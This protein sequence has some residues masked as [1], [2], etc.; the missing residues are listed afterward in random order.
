MAAE[1]EPLT[2]EGLDQP[3]GEV[4][5]AGE[6]VPVFGYAVEVGGGDF[7]LEVAAEDAGLGVGEH[8]AEVLAVGAAV[9]GSVSVVIPAR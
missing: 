5:G 3:H 7:A 4:D 2:G 9:A 1:V 6:G 8:I